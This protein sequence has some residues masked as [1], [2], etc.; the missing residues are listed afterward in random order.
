MFIYQC[1]LANKRYS[2]SVNAVSYLA[3]ESRSALCVFKCS[4]WLAYLTCSVLGAFKS[5]DHSIISRNPILYF[6]LSCKSSC[7]PGICQLQF[8]R[9]P[10]FLQFIYILF[11]LLRGRS[12]QQSDWLPFREWGK[13]SE[14]TLEGGASRVRVTS[15]DDS[16]VD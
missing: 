9:T 4:E 1:Y 10:F 16:R 7:P 13:M 3:Y 12:S 5:S 8:I 11:E 14:R 15:S 2:Q 6:L